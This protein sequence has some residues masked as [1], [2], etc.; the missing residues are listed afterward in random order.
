MF[1][2]D[3]YGGNKVVWLF[4]LSYMSLLFPHRDATSPGL[5]KKNPLMHFGCASYPRTVTSE[6]LGPHE[7]THDTLGP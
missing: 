4:S 6:I 5:L 7:S 3:Y 2:G 1:F